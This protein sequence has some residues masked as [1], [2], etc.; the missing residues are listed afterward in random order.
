MPGR[1]LV[2]CPIDILQNVGLN[3]YLTPPQSTGREKGPENLFKVI[4]KHN[5]RSD[6]QE[7]VIA[8]CQQPGITVL[9]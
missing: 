7:M 1:N 8:I 3:N 4:L 9:G 5:N 6:L 2:S